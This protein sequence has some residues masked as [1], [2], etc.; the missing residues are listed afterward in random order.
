M[1]GPPMPSGPGRA[2][3][4]PL[5]FI[6]GLAAFG[7]LPQIRVNVTLAASFAAASALLLAWWAALLFSSR[8]QGRTLTFEVVLRPQH[9]LQAIAHASIFIYWGIY[10]QPLHDAAALIV[11]QIVFAYAFDMLLAWSRR[12]TYA[13]GF[14]PFPVIFSTNLF[15]RFHD[16][17]FYL[18]FLMVAVGFLAKELIRWNKDGRRTHIFNP[19]SFPLALF[20]IGLIVTHAT[21]ITWGEDIANLLILPP[22]IYLFIFLVSLP[23]QFLFRVTT[24]TLPAVLTTYG[25]SMLYLRLTGTYFFF[26][27]NVPI[28]VFLGMHLLFTDPSTAPRTEL[29]RIIFGVM[30]GASVVGL[31]WL[32]G[33]IGAPTFYDKLL[34]VP[35]MNLMVR[36]I[37][38]V[39]QSRALSWVNPERLGAALV[40]RVR[41][42]VYVSVW[43][44]VFG[45]MSYAKGVGDYHQGHTVP[46]WEQA[47]RADRRN[48]CWNL[49]GLESNSC[50]GGSGWACNEVAILMATGKV[51][52]TMA[53]DE[54]FSRACGSG[55]SSGCDN[56]KVL[57]AGSH[58]FRLGDPQYTDYLLMLRQGKGPISEHSAFDVYT[59][60]CSEGWTSACGNLGGLYLQGT[61]VPQDKTRALLLVTKACDGG[62][63]R[64]CSNLGLMYK[65]GDGV[66]PDNAKALSYLQRACGLG[67]AEA[68]KWL[69]DERGRGGAAQQTPR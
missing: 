54:L 50:R 53:P 65:R 5:A 10:W 63:A 47:C 62:S 49:A 24:M 57:A 55:S 36:R 40:P 22:Q 11:A 52:A 37:D 28:A 41:S 3:A 15:L 26:D 38:L 16:D 60:A 20:S 1:T 34:Q 30:Y 42:A 8:A 25:F 48:A 4:L 27:S 12:D 66:P 29:G 19:S 61:D 59:R 51:P 67:M 35:I 9:Y 45:A 14:G 64:S 21:P 44:L 33:R 32:L 13:L 18:Q 43:I 56:A 7:F 2:L 69:Q 17:W 6:L 39:A 68:C 23:G 46:F 58:D 31:Y